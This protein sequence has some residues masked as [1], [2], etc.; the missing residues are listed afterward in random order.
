M[1]NILKIL[2]KG[3]VVVVPIGVTLYVIYWLGASAE[4]LLQPLLEWL[5][6]LLG[7]SY[8]TG[9]GVVA[10]LLIV[11][12]I[13]LLTYLWLF[14][15][16]VDLV[17]KLLE[18]IPLVKSLYGGLNDLMDFVSKSSGQDK[19]KQL[20]QVVAVDVGEGRTMIGFITSEK[21]EGAPVQLTG[22]LDDDDDNQRVGVYLPRSYQIGGF[23]VF[24][25]KSDL[26]PV[27]MSV[28]DAMRFAMTAGMSGK[29]QAVP[30]AE[31]GE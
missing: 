9:M 10:G 27:D 13:G 18:K 8:I 2:L 21:S 17:G 29:T 26:Q 7:L 20:S 11:F 24:F 31:K 28:E 16:I 12:A 23:T 1:R 25:R 14:R 30:S 19:E 3:L 22:E 15:C 4:K 6:S 5:M